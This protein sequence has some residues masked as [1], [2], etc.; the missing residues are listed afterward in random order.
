MKN[1]NDAALATITAAMI[2]TKLSNSMPYMSAFP[3]NLSMR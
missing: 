1:A 3:H 2:C